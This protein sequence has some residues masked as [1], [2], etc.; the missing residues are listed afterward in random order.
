MQW[1]KAYYGLLVPFV[2]NNLLPI[3][4]EKNTV[5]EYYAFIGH[6]VPVIAVLPGEFRLSQCRH[7]RLGSLDSWPR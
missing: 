3:L 1:P 5:L 6:S 4:D 2:K 7:L